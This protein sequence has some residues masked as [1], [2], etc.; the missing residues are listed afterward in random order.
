MSDGIFLAPIAF[1]FYTAQ[2][3]SGFG[4][5]VVAVTLV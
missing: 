4:S 5:T 3:I 2:S 1:F